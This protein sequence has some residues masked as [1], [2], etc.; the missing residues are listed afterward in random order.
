MAHHIR[1]GLTILIMVQQY[2]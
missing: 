2:P 1:N